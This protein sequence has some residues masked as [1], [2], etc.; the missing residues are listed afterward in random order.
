MPLDPADCNR[1]LAELTGNIPWLRNMNVVG[2][3]GRIKCATDP[4]ALG[5]NVSDREYFQNAL[6]SHDFALSDYVIMRVSQ[7][8]GLMATFPIIKDDGSLD[9]VILAAINLHWIGE[10]AARSAERSGTSVALIDGG[11]T[12][13]AASADQGAFIGTNFAGR[14]LAHDMLANDEGTLTAAGFDGIRRIFAYVRVPW[15]RA[16]LAVGL[17]EA[18]V[19]S[20]IDREISYRLPAACAVWHAG[21]SR[22]L[23]GGERLILRPIRLLVRTAARFG[24]GDLRVRTTDEPWIAEFEP[25]CRCVRRYGAQARRARRGTANRQSAP[26]RAGEPRWP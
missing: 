23:V 3:D 24:C 16:R 17:D 19:H 12:L 22:R 9:G 1:T 7:V 26:R 10:L 13:I 4:H 20:G 25:A 14:P 5:L 8:P 6:H 11:G 15:T 18:L 2:V 21:S